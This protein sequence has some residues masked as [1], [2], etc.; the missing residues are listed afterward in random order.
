M[1]D[2]MTYV[3]NI[4]SKEARI[5]C[6]NVRSDLAWANH[7]SGISSLELLDPFK[8]VVALEILKLYN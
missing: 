8:T 1:Y 3:Y 4:V 5:L 6:F 2:S 7:P